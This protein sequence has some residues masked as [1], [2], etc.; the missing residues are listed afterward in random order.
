MTEYGISDRRRI[1]E[2]LDSLILVL[3]DGA[4]ADI[5]KI[6]LEEIERLERNG[7]I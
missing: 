6:L 7:E 5:A 1:L 3:S 2:A 4:I